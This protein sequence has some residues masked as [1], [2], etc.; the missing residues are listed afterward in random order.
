MFMRAY[1][2]NSVTVCLG[3]C[4]RVCCFVARTDYR[5]GQTSGGGCWFAFASLPFLKRPS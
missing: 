3:N 1:L 2:L 4:L 5:N